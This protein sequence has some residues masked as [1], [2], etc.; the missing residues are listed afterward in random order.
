MGSVTKDSDGRLSSL[1]TPIVVQAL[2]AHYYIF[3]KQPRHCNTNNLHILSVVDYAY[4]CASCEPRPM[5]AT[6]HI[7]AE[8]RTEVC[9]DGIW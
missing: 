9:L 8:S 6:G 3:D 4:R 1:G 7:G 2:L 5:H